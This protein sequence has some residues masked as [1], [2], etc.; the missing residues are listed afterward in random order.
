MRPDV[1]LLLCALHSFGFAVFHLAF[2]K[3]FDWKRELARVGL[4]TR[5]IT[6]IL[7]LRLVYVFLGAGTMCLLFPAELRGTP[8]GRALLWF[9]VLF[10]LGRTI[11]QFVF[12]RINRPMVHALTVLFVLG[13]ALFAW[14]L[15][16]G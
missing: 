16:P 7:N 4:P 14:P 12:L 5:A 15:L 13:A 1:P 3:L 2:W 8:L 9:M 6:Q 11:E 10:W